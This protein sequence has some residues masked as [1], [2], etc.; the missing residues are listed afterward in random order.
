MRGSV[1]ML[2]AGVVG[3]CEAR[4]ERPDLD[5]F[6]SAVDSDV[7]PTVNGCASRTA[8]FRVDATGFV[9]GRIGGFGLVARRTSPD[10][11]SIFLQGC[12]RGEVPRTMSL[13]YWGG[14]RLRRG[15]YDVVPDAREVGEFGFRYVDSR[16]DLESPVSCYDSPSG[17]VTITKSTVERIEGTF[18]VEVRC[19]DFAVVD[20]NRRPQL[21]QFEGR[22]A[23]DLGILRDEVEEPEVPDEPAAETDEAAE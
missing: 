3:A 14:G 19:V 8:G 16:G 2:L 10:V 1:V 5:E 13:N 11:T 12:D 23:A 17:T 20:D 9:E 22:F 18:D 15:T 6:P 7:P 21:A 4:P